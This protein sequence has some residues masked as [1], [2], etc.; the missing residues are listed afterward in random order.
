MAAYALISIKIIL[1]QSKIDTTMAKKSDKTEDRIV[2]VE[3]AFGKTEQFIE[4]NQMIILIV[5][6]AIVVIVLGYFGFKKFYLA[7]KEKEAQGQMFMAEKYFEA[8]S[9]SKALNGDGNYPGFLDIIDQFGITKSAN[10][11]HYYAGIIYLKKG[12]YE[13]A[14]DQ[15]KKFK[16]SDVMVAPMAAGA[17]GDAYM[18]LKQTEKAI[19]YYLKAADMRKNDFT[20]PMLLMKAAWGYEE[21]GKYDQALPLYK[22]I[23]EE[24]ARSNE[25]REIDKYIGRAEELV[26]K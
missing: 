2:A 25:A 19:E 23:K 21:L 20:T 6:G 1:L 13:K 15:L 16:S 11:A 9:L 12:E 22:R 17:I 10:L 26:K 14:I 3:E 8:D 18:E 4:K 5:V 24:Y 7:P